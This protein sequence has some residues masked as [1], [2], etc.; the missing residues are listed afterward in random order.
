MRPPPP[1]SDG[2]DK[3]T[4]DQ[5]ELYR[6]LSPEE[7]PIPL[8]VQPAVVVD[9]LPSEEDIAV[10]VRIYHASRTGGTSGMRV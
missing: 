6:Q 8:L 7:E 1:I 3:V 5:G 2:L 4:S 9:E 10:L